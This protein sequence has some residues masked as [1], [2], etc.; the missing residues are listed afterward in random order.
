MGDRLSEWVEI[1]LLP[2]MMYEDRDAHAAAAG[3]E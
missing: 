3:A 2:H 1:R